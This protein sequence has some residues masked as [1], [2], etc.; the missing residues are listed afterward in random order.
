LAFQIRAVVDAIEADLGR[1]LTS[2]KVD[3]GAA[4][5]DL[6]M[7][8]QADSL[9]L[10]VIRGK[11]LESTALGAAF[12]AGLGAGVWQS[13]D[14]LKSVFKLDKKFEPESFDQ[15]EYASW[16]KACQSAIDFA[17]S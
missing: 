6:L 17:D 7:Q 1:K 12:L 4:A 5:N 13:T 16:L 14:E 3:G 8:I 11:N 10:E 15:N 2:F 9:G